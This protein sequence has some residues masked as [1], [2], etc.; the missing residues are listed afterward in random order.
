[1][2]EITSG[3]VMQAITYDEAI[4]KAGFGKFQKKLM[5]I[6]GFGWATDAMEILLISFI[7]PVITQEWSLTKTEAGFLGTSIFYRHA[8]R[9]LGVGAF[10]R[11][12]RAEDR[13]YRDGSHQRR[14]WAALRFCSLLRLAG[15]AARP[16]RVRRGRHASG[17]LCH[18][19][20]VPALPQTGGVTSC[21]LN[22]FGPWE[23]CLRQVCPG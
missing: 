19:R 3:V 11:P 2:S 10:D 6:C 18:L 16:D 17:G 15:P 7:L 13:I 23:P 21:C 1:M 14:I 22:R 12:G 4:E 9:R 5:L 8:P 20:R